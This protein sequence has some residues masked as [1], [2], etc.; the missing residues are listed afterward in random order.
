LTKTANFRNGFWTIKKKQRKSVGLNGIKASNQSCYWGRIIEATD[1]FLF[2]AGTAK[3]IGHGSS[4]MVG[5][6]SSSMVGH[7]SSSMVGH[8]SSSMV[9]YGHPAW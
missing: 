9:G 5:Y 1:K 4:S 3:I 8:G 2:V 7:G 6:G